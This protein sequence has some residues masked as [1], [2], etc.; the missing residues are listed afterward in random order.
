MY[1]CILFNPQGVIEQ[2]DY[3]GKVQNGTNILNIFILDRFTSSR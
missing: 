1:A 3:K 2:W